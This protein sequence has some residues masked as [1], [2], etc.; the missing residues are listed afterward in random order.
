M[1]VIQP[2]VADRIFA[3]GTATIAG[4]VCSTDILGA[5]VDI[6][7]DA[8]QTPVP[9]GYYFNVAFPTDGVNANNFNDVMDS[10][11]A[12]G[13]DYPAALTTPA[14]GAV[15]KLVTGVSTDS[16]RATSGA[17]LSA[18]TVAD[19]RVAVGESKDGSNAGMTAVTTFSVYTV[20]ST[21]A[22]TM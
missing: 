16:I 5:I 19:F 17:V 6:S 10:G 9:S 7:A 8:T 22:R 1:M 12:D 11:L 3:A 20:D 4:L 18:G 13:D 15:V 14:S 2:V 21:E